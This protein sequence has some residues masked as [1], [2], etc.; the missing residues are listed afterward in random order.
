MRYYQKM[1][2]EDLLRQKDIHYKIQGGDYLIQ[3]LNPEH[4]DSHP[5]MRVD[6]IIGIFQCFSCGMKGN[7]FNHFGEKANPLQ[8]RREL[9]KRKL[10]AKRAESIGL[11][12]P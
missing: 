8:V 11:V 2:V 7:I 9:L 5:S 6:Q 12:L 3:C 1:E 10:N 4:E